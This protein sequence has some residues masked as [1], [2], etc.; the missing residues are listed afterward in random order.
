MDDKEKAF[1]IG[2][3]KLTRETGITIGGCGCCSSPYL[4]E[5]EESESEEGAGY[6]FGYAGMVKWLSPSHKYG[7]EEFRASIIKQN[8]PHHQRGDGAASK[9]D[10]QSAFGA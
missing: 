1:L 3:E 7:W 6:G 9:S 8:A 10:V 2:L 5:L 4:S